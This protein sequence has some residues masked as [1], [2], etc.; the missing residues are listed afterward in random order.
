MVQGLGP[1]GPESPIVGPFADHKDLMPARDVAFFA[2]TGFTTMN[3]GS[4]ASRPPATPT[5]GSCFQRTSSK[6]REFNRRVNAPNALLDLGWSK[7][8]KIANLSAELF[9]NFSKS[10]AS[11]NRSLWL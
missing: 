5:Y 2:E 3:I 1:P 8:D 4:R 10:M 7:G 6:F 11:R 9:G